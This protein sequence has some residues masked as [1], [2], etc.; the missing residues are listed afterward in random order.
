MYLLDQR[1]QTLFPNQ[2]ISSNTFT[3]LQNSISIKLVSVHDIQIVICNLKNKS[4]PVDQFSIKALKYIAD[5]ISP[6]LTNIVNKSFAAGIFP[7]SLKC[8][9]VIPIHK[10][11]SCEVLENYRPISLLPLLIR[12]F[13]RVGYNQY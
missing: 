13:E 4:C 8:A 6:I 12:I 3:T 11:G 9:R 7:Q 2:N 10:G 1:F 5:I